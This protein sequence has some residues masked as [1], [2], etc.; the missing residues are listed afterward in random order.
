MSITNQVLKDDSSLTHWWANTTYLKP[1]QEKRNDY[2]TRDL[3]GELM[4]AFGN[5]KWDTVKTYAQVNSMLA[6]HILVQPGADSLSD[7]IGAQ[8]VQNVSHHIRTPV[9]TNLET[10]NQTLVRTPRGTVSP[11]YKFDGHQPSD[12]ASIFTGLQARTPIVFEWAGQIDNGLAV[13]AVARV[14]VRDRLYNDEPVEHFLLIR[15]GLD[16]SMVIGQQSALPACANAYSTW[17]SNARAD[18]RY[19]HKSSVDV[20]HVVEYLTA[21]LE[22]NFRHVIDQAERMANFYLS[23]IDAARYFERVLLT[24]SGPRYGGRVESVNDIPQRDKSGKDLPHRAAFNRDMNSLKEC[25]RTA[26][27]QVSRSGLHRAF[28]A[29]TFWANHMTQN[30]GGVTAVTERNT[31]QMMPGG[32]RDRLI[33][34]AF[35]IAMSIAA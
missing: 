1:L 24:Q 5:F 10:G 17:L 35:T 20:D 19:S 34:S 21:S 7:V 25:M 9:T 23:S 4:E 27:G 33:N 11:R 8:R 12:I 32:N 15:D 30:R 3:H 13:F 31:G 29:V 22:F 26:N 28:H 14:T 18:L 6:D 2:I 16:G